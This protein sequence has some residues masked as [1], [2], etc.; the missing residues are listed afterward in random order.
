[1]RKPKLDTKVAESMSDDVIRPIDIK[2]SDIARNRA[3][4]FTNGQDG[5][6][7][8]FHD[9]DKKVKIPPPSH[10]RVIREN[11]E[12]YRL[13]L[14]YL[15]GEAPGIPHRDG[16]MINTS[17]YDGNTLIIQTGIDEAT[18]KPRGRQYKNLVSTGWCYQNGLT[19][20]DDQRYEQITCL[21]ISAADW[22]F[23]PIDL[24]TLGLTKEQLL[25]K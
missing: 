3:Q 11:S 24:K 7:I 20:D 12:S 15:P 18:K 8:K 1:M 21:T 16:R 22:D 25:L 9:A 6:T 19:Q 14:L 5:V 17:L 10:V 2:I 13:L 4:V 23:K